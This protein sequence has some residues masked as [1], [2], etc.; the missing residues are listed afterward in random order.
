METTTLGRKQTDGKLQQP[1]DLLIYGRSGAGKTYRAATAPKPIFVATPDPTGHHSI[2]FPVD[3][4]VINEVKQMREVI[5]FF[6]TQEHSYNTLIV[7]GL[8]WM[9][10][11]L[12]SEIGQYWY[13]YRDAKDPDLMP[14]QGRQKVI[15]IFKDL[16][17][18]CVNLT[19]LPLKPVNV[20]F[21][22][23]EERLKEDEEAEYQVRPRI[24]TARINDQFAAFFS[25][26]TYIKPIGELD[27]N[28]YPDPSRVMLFS[29]YKGIL[30]RDRT[31]VF[32]LMGPAVDFTE[33]LKGGDE[34]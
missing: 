5:E 9:H 34:E 4:V 8:S 24:G 33:Y 30:A 18:R 28:G 31:G 20:I 6:E 22:T 10:D 23:L 27:E 2:P 16:V 15:N 3:G 12:V 25:V 17:R 29:E 13:E 32:P 26:I 7:D 21:T 11:L 19:Q 1:V 14:I